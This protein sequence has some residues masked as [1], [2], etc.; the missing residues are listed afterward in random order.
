MVR[1]VWQLHLTGTVA[2]FGTLLHMVLKVGK[3][4]GPRC[5]SDHHCSCPCHTLCAIS[6]EEFRLDLLDWF[7]CHLGTAVSGSTCFCTGTVSGQTFISYWHT[8]PLS[9]SQSIVEKQV[10][11][12]PQ[13][14]MYFDSPQ[15]LQIYTSFFTLAYIC[16][17]MVERPCLLV[18]GAFLNG[19]SWVCFILIFLNSSPP[20]TNSDSFIKIKAL[21]FHR[22]KPRRGLI[23]YTN[24]LYL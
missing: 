9:A 19:C 7:L 16:H 2:R 14:L 17:L 24:K 20:K 21:R 23:N 5:G 6:S 11:L 1:S 8:C 15:A 4:H 22:D 18:T 10:L 13:W 3:A 12:A